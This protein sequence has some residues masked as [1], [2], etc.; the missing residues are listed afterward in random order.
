M[1]KSNPSIEW[2][3]TAIGK[4]VANPKIN[5]MCV[6]V[7]GLVWSRTMNLTKI[8]ANVSTRIESIISTFPSTFPRATP[9]RVM[10]NGAR[11]INSVPK[12]AIVMPVFSCFET[13]SCKKMAPARTNIIGAEADKSEPV[14][15]V[16]LSN[17]KKRSPNPRVMPKKLY[18]QIC[19]QLV[20]VENVG[21]A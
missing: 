13:R 7:S 14:R 11:T 2:S 5:E 6:S 4:S 19:P 21:F 10:R 12:K 8:L 16:V 9:V 17:P 1:K 18:K 3:A 20:L 15:D